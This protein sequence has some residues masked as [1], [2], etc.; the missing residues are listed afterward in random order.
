MDL[1]IFGLPH[2]LSILP[3]N[4]YYFRFYWFIEVTCE[5]V[6][7]CVILSLLCGESASSYGK[8]NFSFFFF[9]C[10]E[11]NMFLRR[12]GRSQFVNLMLFNIFIC[13]ANDNKTIYCTFCRQESTIARSIQFIIYSTNAWYTTTKLASKT[14]QTQQQHLERERESAAVMYGVCGSVQFSHLSHAANTFDLQNSWIISFIDFTCLC[15]WIRL[16]A[17]RI[18]YFLWT[19]S[20]QQIHTINHF[21]IHDIF[22]PS[23]IRMRCALFILGN[24]SHKIG[25]YVHGT[26]TALGIRRLL[27]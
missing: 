11:Y 23:P 24:S 5:F 15:K 27:T 6:I 26:H 9:L 12:F 3:L 21:P 14:K 1:T 10:V 17:L 19:T 16:I 25:F 2:W 18:I 13:Y 22:H 7:T 4:Y 8:F 20:D